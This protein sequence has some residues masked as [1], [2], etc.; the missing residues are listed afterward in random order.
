VELIIYKIKP[1]KDVLKNIKK[2]EKSQNNKIREFITL[3]KLNPLPD[4]YDIKKMSGKHP[5]QF[6]VRFG[7]FRLIYMIDNNEKIIYLLKLER[8]EQ[9]YKK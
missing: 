9:V 7:K 4:G 2:L 6:R 3:L 1:S 8:R 5:P